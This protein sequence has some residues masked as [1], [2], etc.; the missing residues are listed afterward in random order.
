MVYTF[1]D[2]CVIVLRIF[3]VL[4]LIQYFDAYLAIGSMIMEEEDMD[5]NSPLHVSEV[6][7]SMADQSP[8]SVG[9]K[10]MMG[11]ILIGIDEGNTLQ[12]IGLLRTCDGQTL[13]CA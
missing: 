12:L 3:I 6:V 1:Y 8:M 13:M 5:R 11:A 4:G 10:Q 9:Y 7:C 2:F